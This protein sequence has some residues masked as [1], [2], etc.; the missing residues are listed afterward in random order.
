[1]D[2]LMWERKTV[3]KMLVL[4]CR[5]HH[6]N[7]EPPSGRHLCASCRELL[8]YAAVRIEKCRYGADKPAC[9]ACTTHCYQPAFREQIRQVMRYSGPRM[10]VY[11]P[12]TALLYLWRKRT[13]S[14]TFNR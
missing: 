6:G 11:H 2:R 14:C 3:E 13:Q 8:D 5:H 4:H 7:Q 10:L 12:L 9:S 1:M